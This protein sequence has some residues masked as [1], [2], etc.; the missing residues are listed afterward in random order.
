M[1]TATGQE[2]ASGGVKREAC[3]RHGENPCEHTRGPRYP[4]KRKTVH[5]G[6]FFLSRESYCAM[7]QSV[8]SVK[9]RPPMMAF[10]LSR[11]PITG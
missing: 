8:S 6:C 2:K 10:R 1:D 11:V 5:R 9:K 4:T 7:H 3:E